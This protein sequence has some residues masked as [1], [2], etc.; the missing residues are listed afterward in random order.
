L[1]QSH[2]G[3]TKDFLPVYL[4][5]QDLCEDHLKGHG[6]TRALEVLLEHLSLLLLLLLPVVNLGHHLLI[7]ILLHNSSSTSLAEG[8][9]S[10][11]RGDGYSFFGD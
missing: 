8:A 6:Y 3:V 10:G 1:S 5:V 7:G 2:R 9:G 11:L 4:L